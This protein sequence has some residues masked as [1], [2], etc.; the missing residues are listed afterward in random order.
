MI[1]D[2]KMAQVKMTQLCHW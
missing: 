1:L 2:I